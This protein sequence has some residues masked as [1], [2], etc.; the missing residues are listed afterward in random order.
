MK[1]LK[2]TRLPKVGTCVQ[3]WNERSFYEK[4]TVMVR[5]SLDLHNMAL[6]TKN[7]IAVQNT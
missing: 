3:N 6:N 1:K 7:I 4:S 5:E 2:E